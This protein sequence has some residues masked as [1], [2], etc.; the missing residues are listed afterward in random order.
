MNTIDKLTKEIEM[1]TKRIQNAT[2][3][4]HEAMAELTRQIREKLELLEQLQQNNQQ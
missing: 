2:N 3:M 1:L 4:H